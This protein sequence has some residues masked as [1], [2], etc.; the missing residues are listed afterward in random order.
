MCGALRA[1]ADVTGLEPQ[2]ADLMIGTSAGSVMATDLRQGR[3]LAEV[4]NSVHP[5][6][7]GRAEIVRAWG[8][9]PDLGRRIVGSSWV[10][11]RSLVPLSIPTPRPPAFVQRIFPG[12]LLAVGGDAPWHERY[13]PEWPDRP[14]WIV[15][16]DL[17][18]KRR[19]VLHS[20]SHDPRSTLQQAV[21]ASCAVPG[22]YSPI[23]VG[24][25]RL[26]DGGVTSVTNLDLA[27]DSDSHIVIALAPMAFDP[28]DPPG[29]L[30]TMI[31]SRF[32]AQLRRE[33]D[34]VRRAGKRLLILRP[35]GTELEHHGV[36][37]LSSHRNDIIESV[38]YESTVA[39]LST[40][41]VRVLLDPVV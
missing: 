28:R 5:E 2:H 14:L 36:N 17:D 35:T 33:G 37:F 32:N 12:S 34:R 40:D 31:R 27:A 41:R 29:H 13:P 8:S 10:A 11:A 7:E 6:F 3:S 30:H 18:S 20:S 23:R 26:V 4:L 9:L 22:V 24:G 16:S 21:K 1:L 38:A 15:T 25:L 19:I 39:T